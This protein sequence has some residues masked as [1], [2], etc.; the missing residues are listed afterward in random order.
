M[1][2]TVRQATELLSGATRE[3]IYSV[4]RVARDHGLKP[5]KLKGRGNSGK[6]GR[7]HFS[8]S[9]IV[10]ILS[11]HIL[12]K[13]GL[14]AECRRSLL[15]HIGNQA[16]EQ[17]EA[18]LARGQHFVLKTGTRC[19]PEL[20]TMDQIRVIETQR[21]DVIQQLGLSLE[22]IDLAPFIQQVFAAART[23]VAATADQ[24]EGSR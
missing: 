15:L 1:L 9:Q 16:D 12:R 7:Y 17:I 22:R 5:I 14:D 13:T 20:W 2:L 6:G 4:V 10:G 11:Y 18:K 8:V 23:V 3:D 21:A 19:V 24:T